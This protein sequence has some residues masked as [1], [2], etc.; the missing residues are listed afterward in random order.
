MQRQFAADLLRIAGR[1]YIS[2][3]RRS[4]DQQ[5]LDSIPVWDL[6]DLRSA[7]VI[8]RHQVARDGRRLAGVRVA[9]ELEH[10]RAA[11]VGLLGYPRRSSGLTPPGLVGECYV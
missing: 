6:P 3:E 4:N 8:H 7:R 1:Y 5:G 10:L 9:P 11:G 2:P